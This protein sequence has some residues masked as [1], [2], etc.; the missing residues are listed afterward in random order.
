ML[1]LSLTVKSLI[2]LEEARLRCKKI[3]LPVIIA[4]FI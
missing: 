2:N 1:N 3:P 4:C